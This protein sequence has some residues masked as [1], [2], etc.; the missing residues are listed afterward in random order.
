VVSGS[1]TSLTFLMSVCSLTL[2]FSARVKRG[3]MALGATLGSLITFMVIFPAFAAVGA[4]DQS[5][6]DFTFFL[7]PFYAINRI[8]SFDTHFEE[9]SASST[10]GLMVSPG[11]VNF[12]YSFW[13]GLP[14]SLVYLGFSCILLTWATQ[15]LNFAE[16][17]V[18]F[19]PQGQKDA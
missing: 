3:L 9:F 19:L 12:H 15:T 8:G 7:H 16:N 6:K 11:A 2:L 10:P 4:T 18:K 5:M 13:W 17:E 14:Q 1:L